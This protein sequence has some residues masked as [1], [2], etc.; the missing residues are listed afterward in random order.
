MKIQE[1]LQTACE[2][3][4]G[5]REEVYVR[6]VSGFIVEK[7]SNKSPTWL[8]ADLLADDWN[9]VEGPEPFEFETD[10]RDRYLDS[11]KKDLH[12]LLSRIEKLE[13]NVTQLQT[14]EAK[15]P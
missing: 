7:H 6:L 3:R 5:N 15:C 11:V 2:F 4:R 8:T 9:K 13:T 1:V 10:K 12:Y 14:M